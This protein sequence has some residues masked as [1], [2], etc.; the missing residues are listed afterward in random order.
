MKNKAS[1]GREEGTA[2]RGEGGQAVELQSQTRTCC[3]PVP[4]VPPRECAAHVLSVD[5]GIQQH[6]TALVDSSDSNDD[7]EFLLTPPTHSRSFHRVTYTACGF[8][9]RIL[10]FL[11]SSSAKSASEFLGQSKMQPTSESTGPSVFTV[12]NLT[13]SGTCFTTQDGHAGYR[14]R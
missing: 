11:T 13:P 7:R 8:T 4:M 9:E 12:Q 1:W 6:R 3:N 2:E 10:A 5:R 14:R